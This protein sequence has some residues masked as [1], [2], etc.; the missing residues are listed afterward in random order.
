[1][2]NLNAAPITLKV[3]YYQSTS[4][5]APSGL[6]TC[7]DLSVP[8][9]EPGVASGVVS[10]DLATQCGLGSSDDF[11]MLFLEDSASPKTNLFTAFSRTQFNG[12]GFSVEGFPVGNFSGA[13]AEVIGLK[14]TLDNHNKANCFIGA[15]G[16]TVNYQIILSDQ[17]GIPIGSAITGTLAP[18]ETVRALNVFAVARG[19]NPATAYN[20][21]NARARFDETSGTGAA[22]MGFCTQ[23]TDLGGTG[24]ADFRIAK[25]TDANDLRQARKACYGQSSCGTLSTIDKSTVPNTS[26]RNIHYVIFDQPDFIQCSLVTDPADANKLEIMV[27]DPAHNTVTSTTPFG[28][29]APYN[30]LPFTAGGAGARSFYIFTGQR[31]TQSSGVSTRWF[32]DVQID[33]LAGVP[34][35]VSY[36]ITCTSGNGVNIPWLGSTSSTVW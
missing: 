9:T 19:E 2:R 31:S 28:L 5:A 3:R 6:R 13:T 30:V 35:P 32:I 17:T 25:S 23:E 4:A 29:T 34:G 14:A 1:M 27:R 20:Y 16:E 18:Y 33:P 7:T 15:L 10:F 24:S 22:Y 12:V 11:G 21:P 36:G 8:K 26:T